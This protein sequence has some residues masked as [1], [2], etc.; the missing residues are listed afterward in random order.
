MTFGAQAQFQRYRNY[1]V[2]DGLASSEV[3]DLLQDSKGFLW[4]STDLGVSRY[5]GYEFRNFTT[6]DGLPDNTIFDVYEDHAGRIWFVSFSGQLSY[7]LNDRIHT[8]PCNEA[9]AKM[10]R[11]YYIK[12][13]YVDKGDTIWAGSTFD[14]S[15]C[16]APGWE[17]ADIDSFKHTKRKGFLIVVDD[18]G[19]VYGGGAID[20]PDLAVYNRNYEPLY[21]VNLFEEKLVSPGMRYFFTRMPNGNFL[22]TAN[23]RI[24]TFNRTGVLSYGE[25]GAIGICTQ[26]QPDGTILA[27]TYDGVLMWNGSDFSSHS[28]IPKFDRKIVTA[29][30]RDTE[31]GMW[32]CTEG[33]GVFCTTNSA[34]LYYTAD[35]GLPES[36]ITSAAIHNNII[37]TGH[38]DG[39]V[40]RLQGQSVQRLVPE[41]AGTFAGASNRITSILAYNDDEVLASTA[42][43]YYAITTADS[44]IRMIKE[45]GCK[46]MIVS[47][48]GNILAFR[49]RS[50]AKFSS[51][52][53]RILSEYQFAMYADNIYE[54]ARGNTWICA[55]NGLWTCTGEGK[56]TYLGDSIPELA[57]RV[58]AVCESPDGALWAATR[59]NGIVIMYRDTIYRIQHAEGL[60]SNMCRSLLMDGDSTAWVGTVAGLSR[61]MFSLHD[62]LRYSILNYTSENGLLS[63]EVNEIIS[64][65]G[66]LHLVHT[67]GI[68]VFNPADVN[69][70]RFAPPVYIT[71]ITVNDDSVTAG[72]NSFGYDENR[73]S[74]S[75]VG[76]SYREP[77]K[78]RYRYKLE[79][80][81]NDWVYTRLTSASY[82]TLP[83][84]DYRFV[85]QAS[86]NEGV[87]STGQASLGFTILPAWWQTWWLRTMVIV[88]LALMVYAGFRARVR[89]IRKRE[90]KKSLLQNR[91]ATFELNA[92]RAQMN[93]HFVFN[94]INSVQYFITNND[95]D[96]SQK[97]LAKFA[98]LIRYVV[99]NSKLATIPLSKEIEALKLYMDLEAL[100]FENRLRYEI[101]IDENVDVMYLQIPSMLIQPYV[102]NAIWH[103]I[104]HK[105]GD[106]E[107]KISFRMEG[108]I[109]CCIID[110]DGVGRVR[111]QELKMEKER[112]GYKSVGMTNTKER[113]EIIN[114]VTGSNLSVEITDLSDADGNATGTRVKIHVP[115]G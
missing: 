27:G 38:I 65:N 64:A 16:I 46:K 61:I 57:M 44:R 69:D 54:D 66:K 25:M 93:P 11:G 113:L 21:S 40:C 83:P 92:L 36:K 94:S 28:R 78:V 73:V 70:S 81:D 101:H 79:G 97:Y 55:L 59:G 84:G 26:L 108:E 98:K 62:S 76:L 106:G 19:V 96:S 1:D 91:I 72:H 6:D 34:F 115:A 49:F 63:N 42:N 74:F 89:Q 71:E 50:L 109:L 8:L 104:M 3:Y 99:D 18:T 10:M 20:E 5:D 111:S 80:T 87:W 58:T 12:S 51:R 23:S 107:I 60:A 95:A 90:R 9:L 2:K 100:R 114:H 53:F 33:N 13:I 15:F 35:D 67:S 105:K 103:G 22:C 77:G 48:D 7:F 29:I 14:L 31:G 110:D 41:P 102:E 86:S 47:R 17:A 88:L 4:F 43:C 52:E 75:F 85:V 30:L 37:Y 112:E 45:R 24:I 82:Q 56:M 39:A 32:Y 68:S